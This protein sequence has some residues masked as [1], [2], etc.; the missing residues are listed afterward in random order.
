MSGEVA[1][2]QL[3]QRPLA[4]ESGRFGEPI[5]AQDVGLLAADDRPAHDMTLLARAEEELKEA[6][7][8]GRHPTGLQQFSQLTA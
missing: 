8:L 6:L 1:P 2:R 3:G 7:T 4:F 5:T